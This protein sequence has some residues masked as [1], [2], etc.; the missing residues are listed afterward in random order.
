MF[1]FGLCTTWSSKKQSFLTQETG[2]EF[3][4]LHQNSFHHYR[5]FWCFDIQTHSWD[6]IDT[7]IR[8]T[9]RSGHRMAVWK[10]YII[11]FGGFYDPG[12]TS[13]FVLFY[14][15]SQLKRYAL[16]RYLNDLWFFDTQEYKWTL[17]EFKDTASRPSYVCLFSCLD[18]CWTYGV[19]ASQWLF[20]FALCGGHRLTRYANL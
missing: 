17:V 1:L 10:H 2:G 14:R 20:F 19:K 18:G 15:R 12:I 9:A 13:M 4:S 6:R 8:P 7:K 3:S 5:D 16:A 11:L